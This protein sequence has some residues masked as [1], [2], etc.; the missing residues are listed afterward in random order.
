MQAVHTWTNNGQFLP[1][2]YVVTKW[3]IHAT[4]THLTYNLYSYKTW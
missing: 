3:L 4:L 1:F 2:K